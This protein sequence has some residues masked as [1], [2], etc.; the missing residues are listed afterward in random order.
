MSQ[1]WD[2]QAGE[3]V[4]KGHTATGTTWTSDEGNAVVIYEVHRCQCGAHTLDV[5]KS[6]T[7][8]RGGA[9]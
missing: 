6:A 5:F 8:K 4:H 3:L 9:Q 2:E 1:C 7:E